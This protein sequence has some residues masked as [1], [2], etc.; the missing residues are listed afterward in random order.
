MKRL[1][2][3]TATATLLFI[4]S[5]AAHAAQDFGSM[6]TEELATLRGKLQN[7]PEETREAFK[8]EWQKRVDAMSP[9]EKQKYASTETSKAGSDNAGCQ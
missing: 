1:I 6:K 4:G 9:E 8:K 3:M 5:P 7:E 2:S